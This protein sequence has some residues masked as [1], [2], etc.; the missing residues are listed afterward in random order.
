MSIRPSVDERRPRGRAGGVRGTV[1]AFLV[2]ITLGSSVAHAGVEERRGG[3]HVAVGQGIGN[4]MIQWEN[5]TDRVPRVGGI[6]GSGRIRVGYA[7]GPELVLALGTGAWSIHYEQRTS[8]D[9]TITS[10]IVGLETMWFPGG[11]DVF[12]RGLLGRGAILVEAEDTGEDVIDTGIGA[13]LGAGI[14]WNPVS[15]LAVATDLSVGHVEVDGFEDDRRFVQV[16]ALMLTLGW[17][18]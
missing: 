2:A 3:L 18:W 8:R 10:A 5:D 12:L 9:L 17:Y 6:S 4:G 16:G 7:L 11:R 14:E 1:S 15:G 13:E